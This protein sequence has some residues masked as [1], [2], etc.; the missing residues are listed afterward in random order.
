[1]EDSAVVGWGTVGARW[2]SPAAPSVSRAIAESLHTAGIR[3]A[4]GI[5][6][7]GIAPFAAGLA[8]SPIRF[9]HFRHEA[10]AGFAA[11]ESWFETGRPAVVVVTTGPGV[12]NVL[13]P[14]M[15]A[16]VDG[17]RFLLISG[18]TSPQ[19]VSR[20][21][22]QETSLASMPADL[23]RPG[24]IFHD[25]A[26][27]ETVAE[28]EV[29]LARITR[30]L[31]GSRGYVAHL[32]LPL[33]LQTALLP[34]TFAA[35]AHWDQS[36]ASP[37]IAALDRCLAALED[38]ATVLWLGHGSRAAHAELRELAERAN[39]P[40][41]CSPRAKGVFPETHRLFVG[42]SGAGGSDRVKEYFAT[43]R[44]R[45]VVVVGSRLGEVTTFLSDGM[46][47]T[48]SW[49][50]VDTDP[51]AFGAAFPRVP[52]FGIIADARAFATALL[53]RAGTTGFYAKRHT[54][55]T[56]PHLE[57][58]VLAPRSE[59]DVRPTFLMQ[60]LQELVV[61]NTDALIMSE[62]GTSFTWSNAH[63]AF[64]EPG[65][66]RTSATWGSMGHFTT[67]CIGAALANRRP[68][69]AIVGDGAMLMNNEIN[70]AVQYGAR[71]VWIVLNDAQLGLNQHGMLALGM[72]PVETQ[73]PRTDFVTF[74]RAQGADGTHVRCEA[75]LAGAL[76]TALTAP[77]PFVLDVTIDRTMPSPVVAA[78]IRSL[79]QQA[80]G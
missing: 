38:P 11:L 28:L 44:P 8:N 46:C 16:R 62:S 65:R 21:A 9:H 49:I 55:A 24:S 30:G 50:H 22:V 31:S 71:V 19:L 70:T 26:L 23:L 3:E 48:E 52:G 20:G 58:V 1:M 35:H 4:F 74:A 29:A 12:F 25:V 34:G 5:L 15:A 53:D 13:N 37:S 43:H 42:V 80:K 36:V 60:T 40:V 76:R 27:P 17:A 10:G 57:V 18:F 73:M 51:S 68:V 64:D 2:A 66:Y 63:L 32:G 45:H 41:I 59:P 54:A 14:A 78:R 67:G 79:Q 72:S 47:P 56:M 61:R 69:V 6:G 7:G 77:G 33:S 75:E 39:L